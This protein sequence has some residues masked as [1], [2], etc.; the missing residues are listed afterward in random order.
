MLKFLGVHPLVVLKSGRL[1]SASVLYSLKTVKHT[2]ESRSGMVSSSATRPYTSP[3]PV[4]I[5]ESSHETEPVIPEVTE[6]NRAKKYE[7]D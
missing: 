1:I 5:P 6:K 2:I 3:G 4:P 7:T